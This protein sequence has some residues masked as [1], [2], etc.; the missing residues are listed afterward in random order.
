MDFVLQGAE[1]CVHKP[2]LMCQENKNYTNKISKLLSSASAKKEL[3]EFDD[4][5]DIDPAHAFTMQRPDQ[6][7]P[8]YDKNNIERIEQCPH[9]PNVFF[10]RS[11]FDRFRKKPKRTMRKDLALLL[12]D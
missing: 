10:Q 3:S 4:I 2:P 5:D 8:I 7:K 12:S 11:F 9:D 1:G 6:C